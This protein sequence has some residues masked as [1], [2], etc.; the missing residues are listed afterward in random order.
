M[1]DVYSLA[2]T[3]FPLSQVI[4]EQF[5]EY[6]PDMKPVPNNE[7]KHETSDTQ[8]LLS[9]GNRCQYINIL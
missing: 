3:Y 1:C 5:T 7:S 8:P 6:E 9:D 4:T 2:V